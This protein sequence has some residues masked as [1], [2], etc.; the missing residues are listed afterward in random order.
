MPFCAISHDHGVGICRE[1]ATD[2]IKVKLHHGGVGFGQ[3]QRNT[4]IASRAERAKQ[5]DIFIPGI[6]GS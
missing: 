5:V 2:F 6:N 4:R 1:L 3:D